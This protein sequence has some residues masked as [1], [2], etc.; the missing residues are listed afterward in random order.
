[1]QCCYNTNT[2]CL[3]TNSDLLTHSSSPHNGSP[4]TQGDITTANLKSSS[5]GDLTWET[6]FACGGDGVEEPPAPVSGDGGGVELGGEADEVRL[7]IVH[8]GRAPFDR[9]WRAWSVEAERKPGQEYE[10]GEKKGEGRR[11]LQE[12]KQR[13]RHGVRRQRRSG[14]ERRRLGLDVQR[15]GPPRVR[16]RG[17]P[18]G[19]SAAVAA[20]VVDAGGVVKTDASVPCRRRKGTRPWRY[21][22]HSLDRNWVPSHIR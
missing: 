15:D 22:L 2:F 14:R 13:R 4:R 9:R 20:A 11:S 3:I 16:H 10:E 12:V 21:D 5:K 1:M 7:G 6:G 18:P 19:G 17:K 8:H